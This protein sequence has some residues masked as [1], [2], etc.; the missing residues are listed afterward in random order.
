MSRTMSLFLSRLGPPP[1]EGSVG[2][3]NNAIAGALQRDGWQT[4]PYAVPS[5][6]VMEEAMLPLGHADL[7]LKLAAHGQAELALYDDGG[8][9]FC[10]PERRWAKRN[11]VLYHGLAFHQPAWLDNPSI[12]VHC[13][14]SPYLARVLKSLFSLPD[15]HARRCVNPQGMRRITDLT[16]PLPALPDVDG[17]LSSG[18]GGELPASVARQLDGS[19]VAG[20]ALQ[21]G[22][23]DLI[24]TVSILYWLNQFARSHG[25]PPIKLLISESSLPVHRR[26]I[27]DA[28]LADAR[29]T[30]DDFFIRVPHLHREALFRVMEVCRFGLAY[31]RFPEPFGFYVLESVVQGSPV[32][33]NGIGNN[34]FLLPAGHGIVVDENVAMIGS[35]SAPAPPGAWQAAAATIYQDLINPA[36]R[37][38]ECRLGAVRIRQQW[39]T[40]AFR[41]SLRGV[42]EQA[43]LPPPPAP[44]FDEL[45]VRHGPLL[46][47]VDPASGRY[48][49]DYANGVLPVAAR[50]LLAQLPGQSCRDLDSSDMTRIEAEL[51][52][53]RRGLLTLVDG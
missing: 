42:I 23:Q 19:I 44:E 20:H 46:R 12:D 13:A 33:T 27:L 31:N 39:S 48:L 40:D 50:S 4:S 22:K 49:N 6:S 30:C 7:R 32:Y 37:Q 45:T 47:K 34:R 25:T 29:A 36:S 1:Y 53:F 38:Q 35:D 41:Q 2:H 51:G 5:S 18:A 28:M 16:L 14:N 52:L 9:G 3:V 11:V 17:R 43:Y 21:P 8:L 24:A 15:W 26:R 10:A